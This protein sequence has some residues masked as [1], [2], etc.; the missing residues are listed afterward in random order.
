[1]SSPSLFRSRVTKVVD[2]GL[3]AGRSLLAGGGA[4]GRAFE[5]SFEELV[6]LC[7][8]AANGSCVV[9]DVTV[10]GEER[11][12][13]NLSC[14]GGRMVGGRKYCQGLARAISASSL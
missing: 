6:A 5:C 1:M 14:V 3:D 8:V 10:R 7:G 2:L 4:P 13:I 12:V 11:G 9:A